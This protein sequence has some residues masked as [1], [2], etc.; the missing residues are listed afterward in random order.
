[1]N[2]I[3]SKKLIKFNNLSHGFFNKIGG[4]S[5][6]IYNNQVIKFSNDK[7]FIKNRVK[8]SKELINFIPKITNY[9]SHMY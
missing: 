3:K 5:D 6:G 2:L 1:M 4:A 7:E 9:S 8:R